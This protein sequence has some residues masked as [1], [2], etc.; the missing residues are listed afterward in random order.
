MV[1]LKEGGDVE[2]M[3]S[4]PTSHGST[5]IRAG[6]YT[7]G[8]H[9]IEWPGRRASIATLEVCWRQLHNPQEGVH[10]IA[11][12]PALITVWPQCR[13]RGGEA[14]KKGGRAL[15]KGWRV[16]RTGAGTQDRQATHVATK[17]RRWF[18]YERLLASKPVIENR[19]LQ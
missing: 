13:G 9:E 18:T 3:T 17:I 19:G 15:S 5:H 1:L 6:R 10:L 11:N 16:S 7:H 4:H 12:M 8:Q 2:V 14:P